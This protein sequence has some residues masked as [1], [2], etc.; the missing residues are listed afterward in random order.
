M[1][2]RRGS[3]L[4]K[5]LPLRL[6]IREWSL[7]CVSSSCDRTFSD[8]VFSGDRWYTS[9][10]TMPPGPD[11]GWPRSRPLHAIKKQHRT[12]P[13]MRTSWHRIAESKRARIKSLFPFVNYFRFETNHKRAQP[14]HS[15]YVQL[16]GSSIHCF[17]LLVLAALCAP[18]TEKR[19]KKH[20]RLLAWAISTSNWGQKLDLGPIYGFLAAFLV[21]LNSLRFRFTSWLKFR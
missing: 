21:G 17:Q 7:S 10:F 2:R 9:R 1:V 18:H 6:S 19:T 13:A 8:A 11:S 15:P 12:T 16:N 20:S 4:W 5:G 3:A 14:T